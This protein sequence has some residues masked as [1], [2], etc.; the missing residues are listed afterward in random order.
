MTEEQWEMVLQKAAT[1]E[2]RIGEIL[3]QGNGNVADMAFKT[4]VA[5][6]EAHQLYLMLSKIEQIR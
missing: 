3:S 4:G 1:V 2:N 6:A 5:F